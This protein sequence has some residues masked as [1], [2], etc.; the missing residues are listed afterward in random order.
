MTLWKIY[1]TSSKYGPFPI[2]QY[3]YTVCIKQKR[4]V[5][6][7]KEQHVLHLRTTRLTPYSVN[8]NFMKRLRWYFYGCIRQYILRTIQTGHSLLCLSWIGNWWFH[9]YSLGLLHWYYGNHMIVQV[10][11]KETWPIWIN[12]ICRRHA[13]VWSHPVHYPVHLPNPPWLH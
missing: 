2:G 12:Y 11:M 1:I 4:Q 3:R 9:P 7:P 5:H 8:Y 10:P 13:D 6:V